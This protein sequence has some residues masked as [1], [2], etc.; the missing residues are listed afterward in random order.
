MGMDMGDKDHRSGTRNWSGDGA[1]G[2]SGL[3]LFAR[4]RQGAAKSEEGRERGE[5]EKRERD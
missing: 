1:S 3:L 5:A 4:I 2:L